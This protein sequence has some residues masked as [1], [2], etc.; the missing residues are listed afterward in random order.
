MGVVDSKFEHAL[1]AKPTNLCC[2]QNRKDRYKKR[3]ENSVGR[4]DS[5]EMARSIFTT[6]MPQ[7]EQKIASCDAAPE[8]NMDI[9]DS[10]GLGLLREKFRNASNAITRE[11]EAKLTKLPDG[12]T[13]AQITTLKEAV[14]YTASVRRIKRPSFFTVQVTV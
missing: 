14:D 3:S 10:L 12:W 9:H 4:H 1:D 7:P 6:W 2:T 11:K 13:A 8:E 5:V